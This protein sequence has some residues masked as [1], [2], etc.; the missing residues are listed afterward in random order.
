L[1]IT[2]SLCGC[3]AWSNTA[4]FWIQSLL[5]LNSSSVLRSTT[6][7]WAAFCSGD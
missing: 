1:T 7:Y 5:S 2:E 6:I 3:V 4:I